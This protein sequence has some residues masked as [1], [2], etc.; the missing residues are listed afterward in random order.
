M[1][2]KEKKELWQYF[3]NYPKKQYNIYMQKLTE[4]PDYII[5]DEEEADKNKGKWSDYFQNDNPIYLEIGCGSGNFTV[6]NAEKFLDR[7][8]LALELRFKRLVMAAVKSE[9]RGLKNLLFIRK[10]GEKILDFLGENEI[11]GLYINFPDPWT[12]AEH[13]RLISKE[14]FEKLNV[15][16]K[17]D[18]KFFFKTDH[19]GYYLDALE[20]LQSLDGYEVV[21]H[22]DDLYNTEKI[23]ENIQTEFEQMFLSKHNMNIKY[24]E[25]IKK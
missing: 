17:K 2:T 4:Y 23:H 9:K 11:S 19:E 15:V 13:K 1:E 16:M 20:L 21:F 22:T 7:N 5:Y 14:L 12:G 3:F 25:V 10:R 24:I 8:Y 18:G 6:N